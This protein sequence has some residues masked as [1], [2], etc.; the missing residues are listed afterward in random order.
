MLCV[1]YVYILKSENGILFTN[2]MLF[3]TSREKEE[4]WTLVV[5]HYA[6]YISIDIVILFNR[7]EVV[8]L[9]Q[10]FCLYFLRCKLYT[11]F[12]SQ[13]DEK[14]D[15]LRVKLM[16]VDNCGCSVKN[17]CIGLYNWYIRH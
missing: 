5:K 15:N 12:F 6:R 1:C 8:F 11:T 10:T 2:E 17:M 3:V 4:E 7:V 9:H 13:V 16:F 14:L